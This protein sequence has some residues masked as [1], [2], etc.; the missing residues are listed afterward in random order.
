MKLI[1]NIICF[2]LLST[3]SNAFEN[4]KINLGKFSIN[5]YEITIKEY[6]EYA[7]KNNIIT[8]AEKKVED[9]NG[10]LDGKKD[11]DGTIKRLLGKNL[12]VILNLQ[13]I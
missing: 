11:L 3:I 13:H 6:S 8:L 4:P 10:V 5:K 2:V 7:S 9:T 12:R 1:I